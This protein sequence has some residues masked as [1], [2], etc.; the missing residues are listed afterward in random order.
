MTKTHKIIAAIV[1]FLILGT[2]TFFLLKKPVVI[3]FDDITK[4]MVEPYLAGMK[5]TERGE[6]PTNSLLAMAEK[7]STAILLD[8][9]YTKDTK[10]YKIKL[11]D[12]RIG[13]IF[14]GDKFHIKESE[15]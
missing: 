12:D 8:E 9:F 1:L 15:K 7:D 13:Y 6:V 2:A 10:V 11:S 14:I 3:V 4:V 5:I